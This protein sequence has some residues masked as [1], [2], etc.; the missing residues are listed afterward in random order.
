MKMFINHLYLTYLCYTR[1][2]WENKVINI[3]KNKTKKINR[4]IGEINLLYFIYY[5]L[6]KYMRHLKY[7]LYNF[8]SVANRRG[9]PWNFYTKK[10]LKL[11]SLLK[12]RTLKRLLM[13]FTNFIIMRWKQLEFRHSV[14]FSQ[15]GLTSL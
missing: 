15:W 9:I 11:R 8:F 5:I 3:I 10:T 1:R 14:T 4:L 13:I 7:A 2:R 6:V 12:K